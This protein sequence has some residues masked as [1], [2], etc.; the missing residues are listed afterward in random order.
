V[1]A[2]HQLSRPLGN[3]GAANIFAQAS[4]TG[5]T[6]ATTVVSPRVSPAAATLTSKATRAPT[7]LGHCLAAW[8]DE[9]GFATV[10]GGKDFWEWSEPEQLRWQRQHR[11]EECAAEERRRLQREA[12][13]GRRAH[14]SDSTPKVARGDRGRHVQSPK[15]QSPKHQSPKHQS[16]KHQS[17]KHQ[18]PKHTSSGS[19]PTIS[20]CLDG[21]DG[22]RQ[23]VLEAERR[24]GEEADSMTKFARS[25]TSFWTASSRN[26]SLESHAGPVATRSIVGE[27]PGVA[28]P[29]RRRQPLKSGGGTALVSRSG[30]G[31]LRSW[32]GDLPRDEAAWPS[33]QPE[34]LRRVASRGTVESHGKHFHPT[35][36]GAFRR[37]NYLD[38]IEASPCGTPTRADATKPLVAVRGR[39][40][41]HMGD[42][43][44]LPP[45]RL[46]PRH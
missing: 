37:S 34:A 46:R 19:S 6:A 21:T 43:R 30:G 22:W 25:A 45:C 24:A 39:T 13:R 10:W 7:V 27:L 17:P 3:L 44:R 41:E 35:L 1:T 38:L 2:R 18:S 8:S 33:E 5:T 20:F 42:V 9:R 31:G 28:P 4:N 12:R 15:H 16:P 29:A 26:D 40:A 11:A 36:P 32:D 14:G 23:S